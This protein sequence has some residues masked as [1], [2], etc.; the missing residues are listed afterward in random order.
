MI[1]GSE[2]TVQNRR[3]FFEKVAMAFGAAHESVFATV[4]SQATSREMAAIGHAGEWINSTRLTPNSLLG[5]VVLV[6]FWT[7]TCINWLRTLPYVRAWADKYSKDLVVVGVHSPEFP[8]EHDMDNVRRALQF[9]R[10]KHPVV[11]DNDYA[12]WRA[13]GNQYW[14]AFYFIDSHG[15]IRHHHFGEGEY[16]QSEIM[17]QR[18]IGEAGTRASNETLSQIHP[19]GVE[20]PAAWED[21]K[22]TENYL[23][24]KRTENFSSPGGAEQD[25]RHRYASP[26]QLRLN[27]WALVGDWTMGQQAIVTSAPAA[28]IAVRFHA[29]DLHLVMGPSRRNS[30]VRFRVTIDGQPPGRAHGIDADESGNGTAIEQRLYQLIRQPKPIV[31]RQ[32]EIEFRDGEAAAFAFTFG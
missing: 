29:R 6:Q 13:F 30:R 23:G 18:L 28:R 8:F 20:T 5:K 15:R 3:Q 21:L 19:D 2:R 16:E 31:D 32:F 25:K 26:P 11:I 7:Y 12:I 27:Q 22:S 10:I 24:Y 9:L 4:R 14:P 1:I 17:I